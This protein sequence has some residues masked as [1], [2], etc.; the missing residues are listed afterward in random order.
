MAG[1]AIVRRY[2]RGDGGSR[3]SS[4]RIVY[5]LETQMR[6]ELQAVAVYYD[7]CNCCQ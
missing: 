5:L 4:T 7:D 2:D 6:L 1:V 3:S